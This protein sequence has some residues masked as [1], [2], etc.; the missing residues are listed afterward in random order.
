MTMRAT[1]HLEEVLDVDIKEQI[2]KLRLTLGM[3]WEEPRMI[4]DGDDNEVP[5]AIEVEADH[6]ESR[7]WT[8]KLYIMNL[9]DFKPLSVLEPLSYY[10]VGVLNRSFLFFS[11]LVSCLTV[12][13]AALD[14]RNELDNCSTKIF[15]SNKLIAS[16][17]SN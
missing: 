8:P 15:L 5:E 16:G 17:I 13:N 7:L 1:F 12:P 9:V 2:L 14:V 10:R 3:V 11:I 6:A 4:I